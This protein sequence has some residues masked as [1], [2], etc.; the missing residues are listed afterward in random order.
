ML[1]VSEM[2]CL[3]SMC[4]V[5]RRNRMRNVVM[6]MG[7]RRIF[8]RRGQNQDPGRGKTD[9]YIVFC[10][11][12]DFQGGGKTTEIPQFS[13]ICPMSKRVARKVLKW[14]GHVGRMEDER[15][16]KKVY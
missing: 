3:R 11:I 6:S 12:L 2:E 10:P 5:T 7:V 15:L 14:F 1:D 13:S 9:F 8:T 16:T 4:G